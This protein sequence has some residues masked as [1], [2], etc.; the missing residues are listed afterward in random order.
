MYFEFQRIDGKLK[1]QIYAE[2][3]PKLNSRSTRWST[4]FGTEDEVEMSNFADRTI[5]I[6]I[7]DGILGQALRLKVTNGTLDRQVDRA[8]GSSQL[9]IKGGSKSSRTDR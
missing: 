9:N 6:H 7:K 2:L 4:S 5:L 1:Y 8:P 3:C